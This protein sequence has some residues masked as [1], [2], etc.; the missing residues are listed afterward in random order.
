MSDELSYAT[1]KDHPLKRAFMRGIENLSGRQKL[2]PLYHRWQRDHVDKSP[3]MWADALD[4]IKTKLEITAPAGWQT[5]PPETPLVI[6]A[7]HPFGI[8]DGIAIMAIA[9]QLGRPYRVL[10]NNDLLRIP[11]MRAKALPID[12]SATREAVQTNLKSRAEARRL[13]KA[14]TSIIIFPS[15]GVATAERPFGPAEDLPWKLFAARLIEQSDAQ[16]LPIYFE[17][18]NSAVF[19]FVSRYSL[20]LRLSLLVCEFRFRIGAAIKAHVGAPVACAD[21]KRAAGDGAML[22][23]LYLLVH[24]LAPGAAELPRARLLPRPPEARRRYPWDGPVPTPAADRSKREAAS[25]SSGE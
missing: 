23:E 1:D 19:H 9:E 13:L 14:G 16:V 21:L 11:E 5:I 6:I 15:G 18:Q 7:N 20:T 12:F 10:V 2:L 17:G 8:A 3:R 22:D 25:A 4:L 24:R